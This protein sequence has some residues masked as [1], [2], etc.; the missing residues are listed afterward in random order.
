MNDLYVDYGTLNADVLRGLDI[1]KG[2]R[3]GLV[4]S[5]C[6]LEPPGHPSYFV[7][8]IY[9]PRGDTP[10]Y[11][12]QAVI[13]FAEDG[14]YRQVDHYEWRSTKRKE[15]LERLFKP[16]PVDHPRTRAWIKHAY[17]H[18]NICYSSNQITRGPGHPHRDYEP[19][20][21]VFFWPVQRWELPVFVDDKRFSQEYRASEV[22][23]I[24]KEVEAIT[25]HRR[26]HATPENHNA[27][28]LIRKYYP[29]YAPELDLIEKPPV[30]E[31]DWHER[32]NRRPTPEECAATDRLKIGGAIRTH[33]H[34]RCQFC[35]HSWT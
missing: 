26:P 6:F 7:Q 10:N 4:G 27:V 9:T 24:K 21:A 35:G 31:G 20:S 32:L 33:N 14:T 13:F 3:P 23:R 30:Y 28:R 2:V 29:E 15:L 19:T 22:A 8:S 34:D 17:Q 5:G 1:V 16:L 12:P 11:G 25:E 18:L